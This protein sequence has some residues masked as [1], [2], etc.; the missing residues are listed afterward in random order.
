G[1]G[2]DRL[3]AFARGRDLVIV[4]LTAWDSEADAVEFADA[5]RVIEPSALLQRRGARVLVVLGPA[6]PALPARVW[7]APGR[8]ASTMPGRRA[9]A[10]GRSRGCR[11]CGI[12]LLAVASSAGAVR[13][14]S[15]DSGYHLVSTIR[16]GGS[17]GPGELALDA[18]TH[19]LF[20][21]RSSRVTV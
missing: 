1:W 17:G 21:P 5:F 7:R 9:Q 19:R 10:G 8:S 18:A 12:V 20:V 16:L 6:P 13:A 4:W 15:Q 11:T 14:A 3:A 2:G